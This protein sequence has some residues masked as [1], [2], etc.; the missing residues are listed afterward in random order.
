MIQLL[1]FK[2]PNQL[3]VPR[4][5]HTVQAAYGT[6]RHVPALEFPPPIPFSWQGCAQTAVK[7]HIFLRYFPDDQLLVFL[8]YIFSLD[9]VLLILLLFSK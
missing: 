2:D 3:R 6:A 7:Q 9:A 5:S 4:A 1:D 8:I